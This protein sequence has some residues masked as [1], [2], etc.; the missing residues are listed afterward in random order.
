MADNNDLTQRRGDADDVHCRHCSLRSLCLPQSLDDRDLERFNAIVRRPGHFKKGSLLAREGAPLHSLLVVR[1]GCLK[2]VSHTGGREQ[3]T[4]F[5]LPGELVGL[6]GLDTLRYPGS[7][8]ALEAATICDIPYPS[9]DT[10]ATQLPDLRTQLF[11]SMSRTLREDR[12]LM[13][14]FTHQSAEQRLATLLCELSERFRRRGYSAHCFR[15][16]KS[17]AEIGSYLG[18]AMETVSRVL[19]QFQQQGLVTTR[20]REV[21]IHDLAALE[22]L[23]RGDRLMMLSPVPAVPE[24]PEPRVLPLTAARG[25]D[26][27][28]PHRRLGR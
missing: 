11:R 14:H 27:R 26:G 3:L 5:F 20:G 21:R 2:Q 12:L 4:R 18:I 15:F 9:L 24:S 23:A 6:D 16:S 28:A 13:G 7:V 19:G 10:L 25:G 17:R 8:R 1:S 22:T